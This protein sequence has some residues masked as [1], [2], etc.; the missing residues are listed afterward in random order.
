MTLLAWTLG[1]FHTTIL[2][3]VLLRLLYP[4]GG[5]GQALSGLST[6]TGLA[7]FVALWV[8]TVFTTGRAFR[9]LDVLGDSPPA[10]AVYR[11]ALRWGAANGVLFFAAVV[12]ILVANTLASAAP[13]VQIGAI[14]TIAAFEGIIGTLFAFAI[15]AITGLVLAT[16]DLAALRIARAIVSS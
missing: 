3:I 9:G 1:T 10:G 7:L 4:G 11:R 15:G 8:T 14:L 2:G 6:L 12:V 16:I 13:G 5:L